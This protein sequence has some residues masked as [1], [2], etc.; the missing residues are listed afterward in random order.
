MEPALEFRILGVLEV[1]DNGRPVHIGASKERAL[2]AE[3]VLHPNQIVSRER[4]ME[5]VWGESAPA[6]ATATLN[7]Y[8]CHLRAALEP[9]RERRSSPRLLLTREPGYLLAVDPERVDGV[10]FER[11]A[12]EGSRALSAG[13][14]DAAAVTLRTALALWRGEALA[15]FVYEPFARADAIRLEELRLTTIEER[16]EADL[17]LGRHHDLVPEVRRLLDEQPLRERLWGQLMLALYRC[18]RQTEALQAYGEL[19]S[20]LLEEYGIDPSPALR[21]L[22]DDVLHQRPELQAPAAPPRAA[23]AVRAAPAPAA[24]DRTPTNLPTLLTSFVGHEE[25]LGELEHLCTDARLVTLVGAGGVG[26]TR[27]ALE[28]ASRL[29]DMHPHGV[30][31]VELAPLSDPGAIYQQVLRALGVAEDDHRGEVNALLAAVAD[32]RIL[33][34]L[35]NCEHLVDACAVLVENL[36]AASPNVRI[37]ATSRELLRISAETVWRVPSLSTPPPNTDRDELVG[38][39]A[40]R[41]FLDRARAVCPGWQLPAAAAEQVADICARLE[42]IPLAIELA[43]ARV[44][45]LSVGDIAAR[46]DDRFALLSDGPR[47]GPSRHRTLRAAVDWSHDSLTVPE[48]HL[49]QQLSVFSGGFTLQAAEVVCP[50]GDSS[51]PAVLETLT[52][53]VDKSMVV[54]DP[55][56]GV[57]RFRLLETLRQYSAERLA[58]SGESDSAAW[59]HLAWARA[60]AAQAQPHMAG[61]GEAQWLERLAVEHANLRSALGWALHS[62]YVTELLSLATDLG[63]FWEVRGHLS[64][65]RRWLEAALE[66]A[67][68]EAAALRANAH[69]WAGVLAQRQGDHETARQHYEE[70]LALSRQAEDRRG[71]AS[72]LHSLGNLEGLE[73]RMDAA[74]LLYE[75]SLGIGHEVGDQ[76]VAA[77]SLTNLGWIAQS[78]G[79]LVR[80]RR[81]LDEALATW[82]QLGDQQGLAQALTAVAYLALLRRDHPTVTSSCQ[83]SLELQQA[84]GDRYGACWSLTYLGWAAQNDGDVSTARQLHEEALAVRRELGDRYGQ[85]WSL[86]HLGDV[87]RVAGRP[88]EARRLLDDSLDIAREQGD[89]YCI[90]WSLLRRAKLVHTEGDAPAAAALFREGLEVA[91]GRGDRLAAA[92][93]LEGLAATIDRSGSGLEQSARLLGTAHALREATGGPV[94]PADLS[95]YER[96]VRGVREAL[97]E[98]AFLVAWR[99]GRDA[100]VVDLLATT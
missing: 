19:R 93:C 9:G 12:A 67:A 48:R 26:K 83:Q 70:S 57:S 69:R 18:G 64:E 34:V 78:R 38:F 79:D 60:V 40:V 74:T 16:V 25:D 20:V 56:A 49:F 39:E 84:L 87:E 14:P 30:F 52:G 85:A 95:D 43:A 98:E 55:G 3:L 35:D 51:P 6:T 96:N 88:S 8:V 28:V 68:A 66:P 54:A 42:G 82:Q 4:L 45:L 65:G 24:A 23:A 53:L 22:E 41:L 13:D 2:L 36:L 80:A 33:L 37:L 71:T 1:V 73:G 62:G 59:R 75:E 21:R 61:S 11:L 63:H 97:G 94:A 10:R 91:G 27:L 100:D 50:G 86:S 72:A 32:R 47:T 81:F 46:L 15:D 5:V 29:L 92:E 77:A 99:A 31:L 89:T 90:S 17:A 7:T 76:R 44:R 58:E